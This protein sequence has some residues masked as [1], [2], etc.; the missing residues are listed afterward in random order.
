MFCYRK[1][2]SP[3]CP[4]SYTLRKVSSTFTL[5]QKESFHKHVTAGIVS[6]LF[7]L[8]ILKLKPPAEAGFRHRASAEVSEGRGDREGEA[9]RPTGL[10]S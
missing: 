10:E 1:N 2:G 5:L 6:L 8:L 4:E 9:P 7:Q 3:P